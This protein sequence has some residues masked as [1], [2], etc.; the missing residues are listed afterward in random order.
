MKVEMK[1]ILII[2]FVLWTALANAQ[3]YTIDSIAFAPDSLTAP[4]TLSV[5][6]DD[7]YSDTV[8]IGFPFCFMGIQYSQCIVG[9]NGTISFNLAKAQSYCTWFISDSFPSVLPADK[10]NS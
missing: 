4:V 7:T 2:V 6:T 10:S 8:D 9:T 1:E 5:G 3:C